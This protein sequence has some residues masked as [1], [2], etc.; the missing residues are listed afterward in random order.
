VV[1]FKTLS[2]AIAVTTLSFFAIDINSA[3]AALLQFS[4]TTAQEGSGSFLLDTETPVSS[5]IIP[6]LVDGTGAIAEGTLYANAVSNFFFSS[7]GAGTFN[8][9]T[10]DFVLFPTVSFAPGSVA[11]AVG[12]RQCSDPEA[13]CPIQ[14]DLD[15]LGNLA[16]L[17]TLST[18][19]KSYDLFAVFGYQAGVADF[20]FVEDIT[21]QL[22]TAVPAPAVFPGVLAAGALGAVYRKRQRKKVSA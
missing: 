22:A 2:M 18:D 20:T 1:K 10:L 15:Y 19:S 16:E 8:Y 17:P 7:P 14:L 21:G 11:G 6:Q 13:D 4:F 5:E 9:S 12:L 3:Q